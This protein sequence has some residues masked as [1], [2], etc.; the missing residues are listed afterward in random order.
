MKGKWFVGDVAG[1]LSTCLLSILI[2]LAV[3]A[4]VFRYLV[5]SAIAWTEEIE[6]FLMIWIIMI[7]AIYAKRT[8]SLLKMD[9]F[10]NMAPPAVKRFLGI[11]QELVHCGIFLL[12]I[13]YGYRL[14]VQVGN[15]GTSL[16]EIPLYWL[17]ISLPIGAG[18]ML[19]VT[20]AQ[21]YDLIRGQ[22]DT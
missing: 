12:M 13:I 1:I 2:I 8:N 9:I 17:Y 16:L 15:K 20:L 6:T 3:S 11:F 21:L 5:G 19:L 18:G 10:F 14:A 7:G 4:V 22:E